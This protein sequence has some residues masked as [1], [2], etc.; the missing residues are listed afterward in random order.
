MFDSVVACCLRC[1]L[2]LVGALCFINLL[3][4]AV[5]VVRAQFVNYRGGPVNFRCRVDRCRIAQHTRVV[6]APHNVFP[7]Y[8]A[9]RHAATAWTVVTLPAD[10][11]ATRTRPDPFPSPGLGPWETQVSR[12][13]GWV[14]GRDYCPAGRD[15]CEALRHAG[16]TH[17]LFPTSPEMSPEQRDPETNPCIA[18]PADPRAVLNTIVGYLSI[19][20]SYF[21]F[22]IAKWCIFHAHNLA[23]ICFF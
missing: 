11:Y 8:E 2:H 19:Y 4:L 7:R 6:L 14:G 18:Q 22:A 20:C 16:S 9:E 10:N 1:V 23:F 13:P 15:T 12:Y 21:Y 3:F 17:H 5:R